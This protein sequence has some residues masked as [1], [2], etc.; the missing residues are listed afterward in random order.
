MSGL[1]R[2]LLLAV[3]CL[4][5]LCVITAAGNTTLAPN[6]TTPSSPPPTNTTVPVSPT[7]LTPPLVTT[8]APGG[9][10]P[11]GLSAFAR[12]PASRAEPP[13]LC[14]VRAGRGPATWRP[15]RVR[16]GPGRGGRGCGVPWLEGL[17]EARG[18]RV[19]CDPTVFRA[20]VLFK[21]A[22]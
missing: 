15:V 14:V 3:G 12:P 19:V 20:E 1:S 16:L 17:V 13:S 5:A 18:R 8:P 9:P 7:T 21:S 22:S 10:R 4:A 11:N 2:P 6:V